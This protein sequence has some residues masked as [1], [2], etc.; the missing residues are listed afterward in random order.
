MV[1]QTAGR[2]AR[3]LAH[4]VAA[5][6][7]VQLKGCV[8][9]EMSGAMCRDQL[10]A[11]QVSVTGKSGAGWQAI[12]L[13]VQQQCAAYHHNHILYECW[14]VSGMHCYLPTHF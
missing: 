3:R 12:P 13:A 10:D 11:T 4:E 7:T 14:M 9:T 6:D 2:Q 8:G 5:Q 1:M